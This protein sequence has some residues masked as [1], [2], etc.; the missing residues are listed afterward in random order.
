MYWTKKHRTSLALALHTGPAATAAIPW[1]AR[2]GAGANRAVT[3]AT[4]AVAYVCARAAHRSPITNRPRQ[5]EAAG[6]GTVGV[7]DE[8]NA[9][10]LGVMICPRVPTGVGVVGA[11][12]A[13]V[14]WA[15]AAPAG[16]VPAVVAVCRLAY[17]KTLPRWQVDEEHLV[18]PVAAQAERIRG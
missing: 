8:V 12:N 10:G 5:R 7:H 1:V 11:T 14:T 18:S 2:S 3:P 17:L 15:R 6:A 9:L 13:V 4:V 16:R